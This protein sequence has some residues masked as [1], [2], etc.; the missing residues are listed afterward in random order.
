MFLDSPSFTTTNTLLK[1]GIPLSRMICPQLDD[2]EYR[3]MKAHKTLSTHVRPGS[4]H[5]AIKQ[6]PKLS[7]AAIWLDYCCSWGGRQEIRPKEDLRLLLSGQSL[8]PKARVFLTV[9][10]HRMGVGDAMLDAVE[11]ME[12]TAKFGWEV[13]ERRHYQA[14]LF[15]G[16][17]K[18]GQ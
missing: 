15:L 13:R 7:I 9:Y 11:I 17:G 3:A 5:A 1:A 6:A 8:V 18:K 4:M 2:K 10:T 14:M 16:F 12:L